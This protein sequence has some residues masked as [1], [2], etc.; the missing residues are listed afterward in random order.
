MTETKQEAIIRIGT[1][2]DGSITLTGEDVGGNGR[3]AQGSYDPAAE[4]RAKIVAWLM[5]EEEGYPASQ[6]SGFVAMIREDIEAGE[7]LK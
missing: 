1:L 4:E 2:L 3:F 7:H 5:R 6:Y